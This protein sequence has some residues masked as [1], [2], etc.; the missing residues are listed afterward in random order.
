MASTPPPQAE[1]PTRRRIAHRRGVTVVIAL[2][3][4]LLGTAA[5]ASPAAAHPALVASLPADGY[6]VVEE[7]R[8]VVLEFSE[9]VRPADGP[10]LRLARGDGAELRLAVG[11]ERDGALVRGRAASVLAPGEYQAHYR[12]VAQDGDIVAGTVTFTVAPPG[13]PAYGAAG[14]DTGSGDVTTARAVLPSV[15]VLRG[16]QFL[17]LALALGGLVMAAVAGRAAPEL[18]A[19]RPLVRLGAVLAAAGAAGQLVR[20]AGGEVAR[21]PEQVADGGAPA[22]S[23]TALVLLVAAAAAGDRWRQG[24][25]A[26][27][28][29]AGVVL[30]EALR[31]HPRQA[32]AGAGVLLTV[33]H[34]GAAAV[35][36]GGL[37]HVVR[38]AVRGR[39]HASAVRA[40]VLAYGRGAVGLLVLLV[41]TGALSSFLLIPRMEDLVGTLYGR[42]LLGKIAL[43][44]AALA[45]AAVARVRLLRGDAPA[46]GRAVRAEAVLLGVTVVA[47]AALTSVTPARLA[48]A[49]ALT[50]P[51]G[52]VLRVAERAGQVTV[53]AV[54][55]RE[56]LDLRVS[57]PGKEQ[58]TATALAASVR[59]PS[60]TVRPVALEPCGLACWT[61]PV[62]WQDGASQVQVDVRADSFQTRPVR[63]PV[64]LPL[65]PVPDLPDR[66]REV[67]AA[68][69]VVDTVETVTS[70]FGVDVPST[71]RKTG[72]EYLALQPWGSGGATDPVLLDADGQRTLVF[73]LP[74]LGYHF[75]L[76]LDAADRVV[77]ERIVTP[78]TLL[79][80]RNEFP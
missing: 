70:G 49:A 14:L 73:A 40:V 46:P 6:T 12:V 57:V 33:V 72:A 65:T 22:L 35:W 29:L 4:A 23:A 63:L 45:L 52:P 43:V 48:S 66:V 13:T 58:D 41:G 61:G 36:L 80:R 47:A 25:A 27:V 50:A 68:Q 54:I 55:S 34:L 1:V 11:Q 37:V 67:M 79:E 74:A 75:A 71:A 24:R 39:A 3:A 5:T 19:V 64:T 21:I 20:L 28:A 16:A 32:A 18:P 26:G 38:V 8:E 77:A 2:S 10:V 7:T 31:A 44:V 9:S 62:D 59:D 56:R 51:S 42:L 78:N 53:A 60:G 76:R 17:G 15:T 30:L 69:P